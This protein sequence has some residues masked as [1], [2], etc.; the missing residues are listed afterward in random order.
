MHGVVVG[1]GGGVS[2]VNA[3]ILC[4]KLPACRNGQAPFTHPQSPFDWQRLKP[5]AP[6]MVSYCLVTQRTTSSGIGASEEITDIYLQMS[7]TP[8]G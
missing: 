6:G 5:D 7:R 1:G 3:V 2:V 4:W 8:E